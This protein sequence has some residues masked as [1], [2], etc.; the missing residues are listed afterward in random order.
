MQ[1]L[2]DVMRNIIPEKQKEVAEF[3]N[4]YADKVAGQYTVD[5]VRI[6]KKCAFF[7]E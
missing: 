4:E 6:L 5:Q 7:V 1:S 3:R 2:K